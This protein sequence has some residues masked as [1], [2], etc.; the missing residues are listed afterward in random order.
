MSHSEHTP[1]RPRKARAE[2]LQLIHIYEPDEQIML[3][4]L[5]MVLTWPSAKRPEVGLTPKPEQEEQE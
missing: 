5:R 4:G 3:A 2:R 1:K